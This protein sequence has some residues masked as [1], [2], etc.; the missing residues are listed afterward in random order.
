[1]TVEGIAA[2]GKIPALGDF[3]RINAPQSFVG[4]WDRWVQDALLAGR[5]ACGAGWQDCYMSAPIWRFTLAPGLAGPAG[6]I[7]V[8]MPSVDRVG[9]QF[10]LTLFAST[11]VDPVTAHR[12]NA[13][14]FEALEETALDT[15]SD[16][17]SRESLAAALDAM[18]SF[19]QKG[20]GLGAIVNGPA[21]SIFSAV[22]D[23]GVRLI[24]FDGL[25]TAQDAIG[26]FDLD[27]N[28][29]QNA[30]PL[31]LST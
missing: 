1:L 3:F 13:A 17:A 27:A 31:D 14:F 8:M 28:I 19:T 18:R 7:G 24:G 16:N 30:Q 9:R 2:Y 10:P 26:F 11:T 4:P 25:P 6:A 20:Q 12:T 5:Q 21:R 15:L 29:W 23:D 22:V